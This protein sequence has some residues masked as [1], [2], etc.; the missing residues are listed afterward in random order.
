MAMSDH[1][2]GGAPSGAE[3]DPALDRLYREAGGEDPP[4]HLDAVILAAAHRAV[5]AG[6]RARPSV[7]RRWQLPMSIA[8]I[9]VLSVSLVTLVQE[10]GGEQLVQPP[11]PALPSAPPA[12]PPQTAPGPAAVEPSRRPAAAAV[13]DR[14]AERRRDEPVKAP[15]G[16]GALS[17]DTTSEAGPAPAQP[18]AGVAAQLE[19]P[20]RPQPQPFRDSGAAGERRAP[21]PPSA[22]AEDAAARAPVAGRS[23]AS[24]AT[25]PAAKPAPSRSRAAEAR[26]ESAMEESRQAVWQGYENEP[27]QKWLDRIAELKRL[28]RQTDAEAMLTE[29]K[30]RFPAHPVPP[31]LP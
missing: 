27:P 22:P 12:E 2:S 23:A 11:P 25:A 6:P 30:R 17:R 5:G 19:G 28:G 16:T 10:E 21:E 3:R 31:G 13:P 9:V 15:T 20:G 26:K 18:A 4:A 1:N 29:F 24:L 14:I 7:L 8:A